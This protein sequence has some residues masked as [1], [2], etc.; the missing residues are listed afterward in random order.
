MK[1]YE[2]TITMNTRTVLTENFDV[3]FICKPDTKQK[4]LDEI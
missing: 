4:S 3:N 1:N 2:I